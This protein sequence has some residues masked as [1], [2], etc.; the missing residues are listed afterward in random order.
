MKKILAIL[1]TLIMIFS[2]ISVAAEA[3]D[4]SKGKVTATMDFATISDLHYYPESLMSDSQAWTDYVYN[5]TKMF[6]EAETMIRTSIETA[7]TR[8]PDLKYILVPGD[9]TKDGEYEAHT[10]LAAILEEY[11]KHGISD[12]V[13]YASMDE[14]T[15]SSRLG[16]DRHD[17]YGIPQYPE[18]PWDRLILDLKIFHLGR[19]QFEI[20]EAPQRES[21]SVFSFLLS[22]LV[23]W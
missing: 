8:N 14:I 6:P 18:R 10:A 2:A 7:M 15:I 16:L 21:P 5:T 13:F 3:V 19:L 4:N 12:D 20:F 23:G 17:I 9:L 22:I 1:L 11:E